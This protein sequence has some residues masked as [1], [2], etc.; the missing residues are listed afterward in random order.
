LEKLLL[1]EGVEKVTVGRLA[2]RLQCSRRTLY[3]IASSKEALVCIVIDRMLRRQISAALASIDPNWSIVEQLRHIITFGAN[4]Q[5][6]SS[7]WEGMT[8]DPSARKL[9]ETHYRFSATALAKTIAKGI[10]QGE[11][12]D[13]SPDVVAA[14]FEGIIWHFHTPDVVGR[15]KHPPLAILGEVLDWILPALIKQPSVKKRAELQQEVTW[16]LSQA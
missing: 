13:I 9:M 8:S 1:D 15:F 16:P 12:R 4:F 7:G 14:T 10:E 2:A 3:E 11:F 5:F 6:R